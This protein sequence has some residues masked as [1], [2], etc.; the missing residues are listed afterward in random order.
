[1]WRVTRARY[2]AN[3]PASAAAAKATSGADGSAQALRVGQSRRGAR[4]VTS[5]RV[6]LRPNDG[7]VSGQWRQN[8]KEDE[9][10]RVDIERNRFMKLHY[11]WRL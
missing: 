1:M 3:T 5:V 8:R 2:H 9:R 11:L 4:L 10:S 6:A 7:V